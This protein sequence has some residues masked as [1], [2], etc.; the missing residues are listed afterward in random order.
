MD[1][2]LMGFIFVI[3][4]IS[5]LVTLIVANEYN[6]CK[7]KNKIHDSNVIHTEIHTI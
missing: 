3:I 1:Y 6:K 5:I 7:L 4:A 2:A